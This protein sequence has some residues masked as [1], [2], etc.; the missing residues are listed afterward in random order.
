MPNNTDRIERE[1]M[2][3]LNG[4]YADALKQALK[5]QAAFLKKIKDVDDGK[6]KPPQYY[7]DR[8]EVDKWREGFT[9]ELI[10]RQQVI[11]GIIKRLDAAGI[12]AG[13]VILKSMKEIWRVNREETAKLLQGEAK[14]AGINVNFAQ[15]DAHQL[16][17]LMQE[18]QSPFSKI[19]YKNLGQNPAVRRRLQNELS[20]ATILGESQRKIIKRIRAVTGQAQ[21]QARRVAQTE[22]TRVQSQ[23]TYMTEQEAV[24][25]GVNV[26]NRWSTRMVNSRETH[27]A[28]DGK[29]AKHGERFSGSILRFPGDPEAPAGEVINC[30]C[31]LV[32]KVLHPSETI[33][34]NGNVTTG[35][36]EPQARNIDQKVTQKTDEG[37]VDDIKGENISPEN[38]IP[39]N[40]ITDQN[41]FAALAYDFAHSGYSGRPI[42]AGELGDGTYQA[43]TG[44]HRIFAARAAGID[45]PTVTLPYNDDTAAL[46]D[47]LDDEARVEIVDQLYKA[48]KIEK[49]VYRLMTYEDEANFGV[50][51]TYAKTA[52]AKADLWR[53][54]QEAKAKAEEEAKRAA[55][56][57][58][59]KAQ[60]ELA[61]ERA[62]SKEMAEYKAF[63]AEMQAKYGDS[64]WADM[65]DS[66][67]GK[68]ERMERIA[69]KGQ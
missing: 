53:A 11:D 32:P 55:E 65:T 60:Q 62:E 29:W 28:L 37:S 44:S 64:L 41:K 69:Y 27:I 10:R 21:W 45:I 38:I 7:V 24:A 67:Y 1:T 15:Y 43:L 3:R 26:V 40:E 39:V 23:A 47:A 66:E 54:E 49:D 35:K 5:E 16:D 63:Y 18:N 6:I 48:G 68:L 19:A 33:D 14:K 56:E 61:K 13:D 9:R 46:F 30:H 34:E 58:A 52:K 2:A 22:R 8:G 36:E 25:K 57:A 31:V 20:Q 51:E 4:I 12:E 59:A 42:I 17:V 50:S